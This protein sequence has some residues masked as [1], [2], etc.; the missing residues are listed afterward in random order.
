MDVSYICLTH[1]DMPRMC[2]PAASVSASGFDLAVEEF[3]IGCAL[4]LQD[5]H[6]AAFHAREGAVDQDVVAWHVELDLGDDGAARRNGNGLHASQRLAENAAKV[7]DAVENLS[8]EVERGG[9]V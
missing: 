7:V 3:R 5:T 8:N 9:V 4:D 2:E 1:P 6:K